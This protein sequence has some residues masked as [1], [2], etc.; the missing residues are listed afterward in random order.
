MRELKVE[1]MKGEAKKIK[2]GRTFE[3]VPETQLRIH[4]RTNPAVCRGLAR[5]RP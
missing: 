5:I 2:D 1:R 3:Y 4:R